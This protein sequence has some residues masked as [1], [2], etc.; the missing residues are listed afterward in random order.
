MS[1]MLLGV[2]DLL[3]LLPNH[4]YNTSSAP[5]TRTSLESSTEIRFPLSVV[6][7]LDFPRNRG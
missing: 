1:C 7:E 5:R 3:H 4:E 2:I 6:V